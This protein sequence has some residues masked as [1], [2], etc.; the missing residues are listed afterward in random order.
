MKNLRYYLEMMENDLSATYITPEDT[1]YL[2]TITHRDFQIKMAQAGKNASSGRLPATPIPDWMIYDLPARLRPGVILHPDK[3]PTR[4]SVIRNMSK[5]M[6]K[7]VIPYGDIRAIITP[8]GDFFCCY[9]NEYIHGHIIAYAMLVGAIPELEWMSNYRWSDNENSVQYCL[10]LAR[11][12]HETRWRL[13]ESYSFESEI[14][15]DIEWE[16]PIFQR[17]ANVLA[18]VG[19]DIDLIGQSVS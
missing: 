11:K 1:R 18:K 10:C 8:H 5:D 19:I 2:E 6:Q 13:A 17:Y 12:E 9:A 7:K 15:D 14:L 3:K 4:A 16:G